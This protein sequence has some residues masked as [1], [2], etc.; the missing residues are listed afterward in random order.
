MVCILIM[1]FTFGANGLNTDV[2]WADELTSLGHMGAFDPPYSPAQILESIA[3]KS[4]QHMP[5]F[6]LMDA[7]WANVAGW[8]QVAMRMISLLSGVLLIAWVY[9]FGS[10]LVNRRTGVVASL[11]LGSSAFMMVY[12]HEIRMYALFVMLAVMH[13]WLYWR[14]A[15]TQRQSIWMWSGFIITTSALFYTHIFATVLFAGL[16]VYHIIFVAKSRHGLMLILGWGV[17]AFF[18]LPYVPTVIKGF[19]LAT[20]KV[21]TFTTAL[22]TPELLQTFGYLISNGFVLLWLPLVGALAYALWKTRHRMM[23]RFLFVTIAMFVTLVLINYRFGLVPLRRARYLLLMWFPMMILFAY[24]LT[25]LPRRKIL[26]GIAVIIWFGAGYNLYRSPT[27]ADH[28]GTI[29]AVQYYPPMQDYVVALKVKTR[30]LDYVVGFTDA[31]FVNHR[32][33]HNKSTSDYYMEGQLGI[34]GVFIPSYFD[35]EDLIIDIPEKLA[36]HPDLL[37]TYN[38]TQVSENFDIALNMIQESYR[39]CD[40]VLDRS[41]LF[42]QRYVDSVLSCERDYAP[43]HYDKGVT[44]LD[45]YIDY[46]S[47]TNTLHVITGWEVADEKLLDQYNVSI[48]IVTPDWQNV[49]Q[50]DRH[51]YDDILKWYRAEL[52]TENLEA[53][54]Y[55]VMVIVYD[56]ETGEKVQGV[57]MI[58]GETG[59]ILPIAIF[60]VEES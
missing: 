43:I 2:I 41:D 8:S 55:R 53:G 51:L 48:Q 28:I 1:T 21:S 14:L 42:S 50:T 27:F 46:S 33:K 47:E 16:G 54:D 5:L 11:L 37:F 13:T 57:D 9:R 30:P 29:D 20:N 56:N 4:S 25:M 44:I 59:T 12:L 45:K 40:V 60:T 15:H 17:G 35:E 38:P 7:L 3:E 18:F 52:S 26:T 34:D 31:D 24:G 19:T 49:G 22:S 10:D 6:F 36:N 39:A 58:T 32:G 23:L